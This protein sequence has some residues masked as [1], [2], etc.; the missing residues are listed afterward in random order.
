[1]DGEAKAVSIPPDSRKTGPDRASAAVGERRVRGEAVGHRGGRGARRAALNRALLRFRLGSG[2]AS[3]NPAA[4]C[5]SMKIELS[6]ESWLL[7]DERILTESI[8]EAGW[9]NEERRRARRREATPRTISARSSGMAFDIGR[10][11]CSLWGSSLGEAAADRCRLRMRERKSRSVCRARESVCVRVCSCMGRGWPGQRG[12]REKAGS[13]S[14]SSSSSASRRPRPRARATAAV[15]SS[16]RHLL[17]GVRRATDKGPRPARLRALDHARYRRR[18]EGSGQGGAACDA[19]LDRPRPAP[20]AFAPASLSRLPLPMSGLSS[21]FLIGN[22][23]TRD[24]GAVA[25]PTSRLL[26]RPPPLPARSP[27]C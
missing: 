23:S 20:R 24:E 11:V 15:A 5:S 12:R 1:V 9:A 21:S 25:D 26:Q 6:Q 16:G 17:P 13:S 2:P 18:E 4:A 19:L 10:R 7:R 3:P 27:S 8:G 14:S 22:S